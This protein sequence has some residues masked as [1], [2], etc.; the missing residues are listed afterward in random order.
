MEQEPERKD[1]LLPEETEDY[2]GPI[3]PFLDHLEDLRWMLIKVVVSVLMG[4][5]I[6]LVAGNHLV[7]FLEWPL[8]NAEM[9]VSE[10]RKPVP[11]SLLGTNIARLPRDKA[12]GVFGTNWLTGIEL[13]PQQVGTNFV[14]TLKPAPP[15][16]AG[17]YSLNTIKLKNY[18]PIEA[19]L[20]ALKL[21]LYGGLVIS[22]PFVIYFIGSFVLPALKMTEKKLLYQ[23][24]GFG[25]FLFF[26]GVA[27]CYLAI[28]QVALLATVQFSGWLGFGADEWRAEAYISFVC[29]F[30]L[31]MGIAFQ[32]P[33]VLLTMVKIGLLDYQKLTKFRTYWVVINMVICAFVTPS[34]DPVTMLAMAIPLQILYELS[35]LIARY[36]AR[37]EPKDEDGK[38]VR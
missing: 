4:M 26:L 38:Q 31:G 24:V 2:G 21:A 17:S 20:I 1:G 22:A 8:R 18:G 14:L 12:E 29:K 15:A 25:T 28:V 34:G 37:N 5:L 7:H 9:S 16:E 30:M 35:V 11:I 10:S 33:V 27:F 23:I 3:K 6:S 32:I 19:F 13:V 36:W